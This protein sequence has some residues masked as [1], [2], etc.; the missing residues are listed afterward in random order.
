MGGDNSAL[1]CHVLLLGCYRLERMTYKD[2][3][4]CGYKSAGSILD[5]FKNLGVPFTAM[6][7]A[8]KYG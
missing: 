6:G 7:T 1:S 5:D 2:A 3:I 8:Q 4:E